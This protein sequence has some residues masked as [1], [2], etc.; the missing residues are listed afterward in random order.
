MTDPL[1]QIANEGAALDQ[2][3]ALPGDA[4]QQPAPPAVDA[5]QEGAAFWALVP[6]T[7]GS[8][9]CMA[10]P[11]LREVYGEEKCLAW[12]VAMQAVAKK[13]G[14]NVVNSPEAVLVAASSVFV[15]PT[16]VTMV[17]HAQA[18]KRAAASPRP[19]SAPGEDAT[20]TTTRIDGAAPPSIND[21]AGAQ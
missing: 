17:K 8:I 10:F 20:S 5:D 12:G 14:W 16:A 13:R 9:L 4:Q 6:K 11:E 1:D 19:A 2:G 7:F 21:Q 18:R 15:I 3:A